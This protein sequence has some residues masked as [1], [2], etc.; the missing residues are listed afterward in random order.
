MT[1][2]L[3]EDDKDLAEMYRLQL[4]HGGH[5]VIVALTAQGALDALDGNTVDLILLDVMLPGHNGLS[6][7]HELRSYED[8]RQLPIV[9]LSSLSVKE[10]GIS[11]QALRDLGVQ[12]YLNKARTKPPQLLA[13][14]AQYG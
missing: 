1:I 5:K 6:V 12:E 9:I 7:L 3:V 13:A 2:L 4:S 10:L 8:L 14:V 11:P